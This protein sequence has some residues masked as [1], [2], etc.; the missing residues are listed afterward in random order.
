MDPRDP[1]LGCVDSGTGFFKCRN[2]EGLSFFS[3]GHQ[4]GWRRGGGKDQ[5]AV[6]SQIL[7]LISSAVMHATVQQHMLFDA[8]AY[9]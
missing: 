2:W 4:G 8:S 6:M 5:F 9:V 3:P 1:E 7:S